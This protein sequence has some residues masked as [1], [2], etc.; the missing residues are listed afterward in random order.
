[1]RSASVPLMCIRL[2][3]RNVRLCALHRGAQTRGT[4]RLTTPNPSRYITGR[5]K[6]VQGQ[7]GLPELRLQNSVLS[8]GSLRPNPLNRDFRLEA[9]WR[10]NR[11]RKTPASVRPSALNEASEL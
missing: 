11:P 8:G 6:V 9:A 7:E 4:Q 10:A 3:R 1:M 5:A 2:R